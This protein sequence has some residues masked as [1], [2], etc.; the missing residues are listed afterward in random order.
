MELNIYLNC[1][2]YSLK[3]FVKL[4]D[5]GPYDY[6]RQWNQTYPL[7]V[8]ADCS[9]GFSKPLFVNTFSSIGLSYLFRTLDKNSENYDP[10]IKNDFQQEI[11]GYVLIKL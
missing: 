10:S 8:K 9:Y 2:N 3:G 7:Q 4:N 6:N 1:N 5:W 11:T